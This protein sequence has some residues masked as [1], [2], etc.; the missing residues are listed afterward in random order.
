M[1]FESTD[2]GAAFALFDCQI[3]S[4]IPFLSAMSLLGAKDNDPIATLRLLWLQYGKSKQDLER[5][6][7]Y[8]Y[9]ADI[10]HR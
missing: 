3:N 5:G 9:S 1:A 6:M 10:K 8:L 2:V 4:G 7:Y